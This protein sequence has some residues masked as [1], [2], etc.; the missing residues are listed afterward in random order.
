[1]DFYTPPHSPISLIQWR[2][3][4]KNEYPETW[5]ALVS[6]AE[7]VPLA[8]AEVR[9]AE[10]VKLALA[11]WFHNSPNNAQYSYIGAHGLV[12]PEGKCVGIGASLNTNEHAK[13]DE[14]WT[15]YTQGELLGG[16]WLGACGT[17]DAADALTGFLQTA[18]RV[19]IPYIYGF[20]DPKN[21]SP[22]RELKPILLKLIELTRTNDVV[23]LD[24]ELAM[25]RRAVPHTTVEL[26]YPAFTTAGQRKYVNVDTIETEVGMP[27]RHLLENQAL[28]AVRST[29]QRGIR[30]R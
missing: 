14:V 21:V 19:V 20:R 15:W 4:R 22:S 1:M 27:F 25:L 6:F 5:D 28:R 16:L 12:T 30:G 9:T 8:H 18:E 3:P 29:G 24:E 13:W 7:E 2:D 11:K 26:Y 23:W 17:R 10:D